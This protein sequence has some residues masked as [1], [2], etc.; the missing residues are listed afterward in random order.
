M[1]PVNLERSGINKKNKQSNVNGF[2]S[3]SLTDNHE[4]LKSL[5][6]K[7]AKHGVPD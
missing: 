4:N 7:F 2:A 6:L 5:A 1:N 3:D